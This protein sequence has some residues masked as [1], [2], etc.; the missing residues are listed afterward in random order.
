VT[1]VAWTHAP[2]LGRDVAGA[3]AILREQQRTDEANGHALTKFVLDEPHGFMSCGIL[4]KG[5]AHL[6]CEAC[7]EHHVVAL[8]ELTGSRGWMA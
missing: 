4:A 6:Y 1:S 5:F 2:P 8:P 3:N 7:G